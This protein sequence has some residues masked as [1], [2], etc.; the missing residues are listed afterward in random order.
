MNYKNIKKK[1]SKAI[2]LANLYLFSC[3]IANSQTPDCFENINRG[4]FSFNMALDKVV[5]KPVAK[6]YSYL[7]DFL[8]DGVKN[9]TSNISE[10]VTVPNY[11]LQGEFKKAIH[12]TGRFLINTTAGIFGFF[13]P[14][15]KLG[16]AKQES[17]DYGLTLGVWGV[18]HGCFVM[19]PIFGPSTLRDTVGKV[20]NTLLDPFYMT[21]VGSKE[22]AFGN[23]LGDTTYYLEQG[24]DKVDFRARNMAAFDDLEK[25]S[26]DLYASVR[27]AYL[28]KRDS[29]IKKDSSSEDEWKKFK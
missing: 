11:L 13:D 10:T 21:T 26:V 2:F 1:I 12:D 29:M 17:N 7:P 28:Q 8:Q 19:L 23:N 6:G 4:I 9:M 16:L 5:F 25:N 24:F 22:Y 14:A 20:G 3:G 27:S 15:T 18:S